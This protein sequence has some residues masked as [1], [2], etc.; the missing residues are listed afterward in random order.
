MVCRDSGQQVEAQSRIPFRGAVDAIGR[1][2]KAH[3]DPVLFDQDPA[4]LPFV[5][6]DAA[7]RD[8]LLTQKPDRLQQSFI[9]EIERVIAAD[10]QCR[11]GGPAILATKRRQQLRGRIEGLADRPETRNTPRSCYRGLEVGKYELM[12]VQV[13]QQARVEEIRPAVANPH[14]VTG[15]GNA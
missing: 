12:S 9:A 2:V 11:E 13:V 1:R 7:V 15:E 5:R 4:R 10:R 6:H 14:D 8:A 3:P